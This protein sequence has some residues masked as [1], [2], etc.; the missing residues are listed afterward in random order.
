VGRELQKHYGQPP[1]VVMTLPI[2]EGLDG[3]QKMSKSLGNYI[4]IHEPPDEMF[5]KIM[6]ISDEL[7]WRYFALLSFEAETTIQAWRRE[8]AEGANPRDIKF[9]LAR[10]LVAR[11]HDQ[12]CAAKA[13]ENFI[14]RFQ[15]G[16]LPEDMPERT[17]QSVA[18]SMAI[19]VAMKEADL[20]KTTSEAR[21]MLLQGAVR[22]DGARVTDVDLA[23]PAGASHVVQVGK[24]RF[25]RITIA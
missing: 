4:G 5:G 3:V 13:Q 20:T 22:L 15:K 23:L 7:M 9:R 19:S 8:I 25:A 17:L 1:Q 2:L 6:S 12:A 16:Q 10:E 21:R 14:A 18:G 24:R 11:F